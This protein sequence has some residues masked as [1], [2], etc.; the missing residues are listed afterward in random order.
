M[1]YANCGL[2]YYIGGEIEKRDDL[3]IASPERL[4]DRYRIDVRTSQEVISIDRQEREVVIKD[5]GSGV[6]FKEGYDKLILYP[7][8]APTKLPLP[9]IDSSTEN[10]AFLD[11]RTWEE[12]NQTGTIRAMKPQPKWRR[13]PDKGGS[14]SYSLPRMSAGV[15]NAAAL[16]EY[17]EERFS[18][19]R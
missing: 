17:M 14:R 3:F 11:V 9:G 4:R 8:A 13:L 1:S 19:K 18:Q 12:V 10:T 5:H 6:E 2:P 7:G 16:K 15:N